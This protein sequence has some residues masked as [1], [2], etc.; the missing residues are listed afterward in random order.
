MMDAWLALAKGFGAR[1]AH[2]GVSAA[3]HRALRFYRAYG[4]EEQP[5]WSS[6]SGHVFATT[7]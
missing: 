5:E 4:L 1:G 2:L 7:L 3:N 6:R